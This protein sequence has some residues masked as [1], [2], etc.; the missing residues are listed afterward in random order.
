[1]HALQYSTLGEVSSSAARLA[2][3]TQKTQQE[4]ALEAFR[5]AGNNLNDLQQTQ[6]RPV[7]DRIEK[8]TGTADADGNDVA[9]AVDELIANVR[10]RWLEVTKQSPEVRQQIRSV[11]YSRTRQLVDGIT[12]SSDR[13]DVVRKIESVQDL[14]NAELF[15]VATDDIFLMAVQLLMA[16]EEWTQ[17]PPSDSLKATADQLL[18]SLGAEQ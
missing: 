4:S 7:L 17:G 8:I 13:R 10:E 18:L 5:A 6:L 1:V 11:L 3:A 14:V 9:S 15:V 2:R 12:A 16:L